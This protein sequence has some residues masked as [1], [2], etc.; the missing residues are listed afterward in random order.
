MKK[1]AIFSLF[2]G[3]LVLVLVS[4]LPVYGTRAEWE[5]LEIFKFHDPGRDLDHALRILEEKK[6]FYGEDSAELCP[7]IEDAGR[8]YRRLQD[9]VNAQD[10]FERSLDLKKQK[11]MDDR[12]IDST[13]LY[14]A[15]IYFHRGYYLKAEQ[16][17]L[18]ILEHQQNIL[19][20][21]DPRIANTLHSL[22]ILYRWQGRYD[23]ASSHY[24]KAISILETHD[25]PALPYCL[26]DYAF[27]HFYQGNFTEA[28]ELFGKALVALEKR[29]QQEGRE[30]LDVVSFA[31]Y[32]VD[33]I[34]AQGRFHE[35]EIMY[36]QLQGMVRER[37]GKGQFN[38]KI[39]HLAIGRF[40]RNWD[41]PM[42]A[43]QHYRYVASIFFLIG[44][45]PNMTFFLEEIAGFYLEQGNFE[46]SEII[47]QKTKEAV[48]SEY[49][50]DHPA[51]ASTLK[52]LGVLYREWGR[53][54]GDPEK[55]ERS[56]KYL[57]D[58]IERISRFA[59]ML[60]PSRSCAL[61]ELALLHH[62]RGQL[63]QADLLYR[64]AI[65]NY[66]D[67]FGP[68]FGKLRQLLFD[69][70]RLCRERGDIPEAD[71]LEEWAVSVPDIGRWIE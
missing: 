45:V 10:C 3:L 40:Y 55:Y 17:T 9:L 22:A 14:L 67:G 48:E 61:H 41:R 15:N 26:K 6:K 43:E 27:L 64:Q 12:T 32:L 44:I 18:K 31:I 11:G 13:R 59:S 66:V 1:M 57:K 19:N 20:A 62:Y 30:Y 16:T 51:F 68:R 47:L 39:F 7:Y 63:K 21:D 36:E 24:L 50:K 4:P 70:S 71:D 65:N 34:S 23:E 37:Y 54:S 28:E 35:A 42:E 56:E 46:E 38:E 2:V 52:N 58:S 5:D 25:D 29:E 69:L 49:G 33:S 53:I 60:H 8:E